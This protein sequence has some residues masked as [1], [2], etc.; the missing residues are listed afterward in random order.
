MEGREGEESI[1]SELETIWKMEWRWMDPCVNDVNDGCLATYEGTTE[2]IFRVSGK[3]QTHN[4][5]NGGRML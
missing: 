1:F 2:T 3:N 4:L 5:R